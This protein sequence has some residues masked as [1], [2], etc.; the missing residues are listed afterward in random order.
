MIV[1]QHIGPFEI[2]RELG[3]GAMG[4]VYLARFRKDDRVI[5]VALKVVAFGLLGNESAIARF[6]REASILKQLKHPHIVRLYATGRYKQM[7]FIAMEYVEGESLDKTLARRNGRLAW[8]DLVSY[9]KQLCEAL[10]H[11]HDKGIIHRDLKPSNLMVTKEGVLKLTDFGIAKDTD[12]TALTGQNS[13]IGTAAYMSPEQ[14]RGEQNLSNKSDLYSLGIVFYECVTGKK[15][16]TATTTVEMFL[17]HVNEKPIR[18]IRL[19]PEIPVW[20][21]NLIMFLLEKEKSHRPL[22][23]RMVGKLLEDI[24]EKVQSQRSV[25]ADMAN[26]RRMDRPLGDQP[27][28]AADKDTAWLLRDGAGKKK[29]KKKKPVPFLQK[30]WP[31]AVGFGF[32]LMLIV[33]LVIYQLQPESLEQAYARVENAATPQA[34]L[35]ATQQFLASHGTYDDP[36]VAQALE[37]Y[38]DA[39]ATEAARLLEKRFN[40]KFKDNSENFDDASYKLAITAL[41]MEKEGNLS[42]A[43]DLWTE[44]KAKQPAITIQQLLNEEAV[45]RSRL[46]WV[47]ERRLK[48][49]RQKVPETIRQLQQRIADER[50]TGVFRTYETLN[51]EGE[52]VRALRLEFF[53][54]QPKAKQTWEGLA[55]QTEGAPDART[56]FLLATQKAALISG[57]TSMNPRADRKMLLESKLAEVK[58]EWPKVANDTNAGARRRDLRNT[59]HDITMLYADEVHEDIVP[60]VKEANAFLT[61]IE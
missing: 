31:K 56:W 57:A 8:E 32:V 13:T 29:K 23:A 9:G 58:A 42:R 39:Q 21:D 20:L 11:A 12:V 55:K 53:G 54:D 27:M 2:D 60:I 52:A 45:N 49:I 22:D 46:G 3:N 36:R 6:D 25:G 48:L 41:E 43:S 4:T 33:G 24:E 1:G 7:P 40:S 28:D 51:P 14:C 5:P 18:P 37:I 59:L 30:T 35:A 44:V 16:F 17:K 61:S 38:Q 15:P 34:K 50:I 10:Q 47:A 26:A 19:N